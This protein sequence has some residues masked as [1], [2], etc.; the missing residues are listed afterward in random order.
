MTDAELE[1]DPVTGLF[2]YLTVAELAQLT[3]LQVS[4]VNTKMSHIRKGSEVPTSLPEFV[5]LGGRT[6]FP[7][8]YVRRWSLTCL[9]QPTTIAA[10]VSPPKRLGRPS[11]QHNA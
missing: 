1:I 3:G 2:R 4:T 5:R 6:V 10:D 7:V 9:G 8:C 11:K